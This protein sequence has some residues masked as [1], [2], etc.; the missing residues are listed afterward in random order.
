MV[1]PFKRPTWRR[2]LDS[3]AIPPSDRPQ[4][5]ESLISGAGFGYTNSNFNGEKF[6]GGFGPTSIYNTDYRTLRERSE[7]LFTDNLFASGIITRFVTQ[8]VNTGISLEATPL[9]TVLG[10]TDDYIEDWAERV[11]DLHKIWEWNKDLCDYSRMRTYGE[12]LAE[13]RAESLV[14]GD[15]LVVLR[16]NS[17]GLPCI[18]TISGALIDT[19]ATR[20]TDSA[21]IHGVEVDSSGEH[22]GY[23]I[24]QEDGTYKRLAARSANGRRKAWLVYGSKKRMDATRGVPLLS[25][26]L[27]SLKEIDRYRDAA[28][29]K[30]V[31]N[32]IL[33]M[34]I[35]RELPGVV[36]TTPISGGAVKRSLAETT[37]PDGSKREFALAGQ[38][39]GMVFENLAPGEEPVGFDSKGTDINF[40]EFQN[41]VIDAI[42]WSMGMPPSKLKLAYS[43][44]YSASQAELNDFKTLV[45]MDRT[46]LASSVCQPFYEEELAAYVASGKVDAPGYLE[47]YLNPKK[48]DIYG[49]WVYAEWSGVVQPSTDLLKVTKAYIEQINAGLT[50]RKLAVR[51]LNG[52]SA[53]DI[54][55]GLKREDE[56]FVKKEDKV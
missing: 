37:S 16:T 3:V 51:E 28:L 38:I 46:L 50:T 49:A 2:E 22:T 45:N 47:S 35:K 5:I 29:R 14:T 6:I 54:F 33:A 53:R 20:L 42:A 41:A 17:V 4:A 30:A 1:N 23:F 21:V 11:E 43:S 44:N 40:P 19:P 52:R 25:I 15:I 34:F 8:E 26:V 36:G 48:Y 31:I 55:R 10:L 7:Q 24:L 32:S 13:I 27:Q 9:R 39:P 56:Q 12:I 18:Q